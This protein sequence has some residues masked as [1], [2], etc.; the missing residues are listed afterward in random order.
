MLSPAEWQILFISFGIAARAVAWALLVAIP[1]AW[2]LSRRSFPGKSALDAIAHLPLLLPPVLIGFLLL[3]A[4]GRR[5][6]IGHWL[7]ATFGIRLA[8][9]ADGAALA[10]AVMILPLLVRA[11]RLSIEAIDNGLIDAASVL[12]APPLDRFFSIVLPLAAPGVIAGAMTAFAAGLGEFG[13]VITFAGNV[14]GVTQTL[15]L[16]IYAALQAPDGDAHAFRLAWISFSCAI[17][18]FAAAETLQTWSRKRR[19]S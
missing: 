8:F 10:T 3:L 12:R 16:A 9:T 1:L 13:A 4:L 6:P 17:I 5:A 19:A 11:I 15:P 14:P 18:G 2:A 7:D